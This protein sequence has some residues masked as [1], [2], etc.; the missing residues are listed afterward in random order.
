MN[1]NNAQMGR[2]RYSSGSGGDV[3]GGWPRADH[4]YFCVSSWGPWPDCTSLSSLK[5]WV[6]VRL[7]LAD[8]T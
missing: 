7:A 2:A 5:L 1:Y 8:A 4:Q 3:G 6:G